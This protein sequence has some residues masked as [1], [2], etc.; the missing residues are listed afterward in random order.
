[1]V[2]PSG[3]LSGPKPASLFLCKA[4]PSHRGRE[5]DSASPF[6]ALRY[7]RPSVRNERTA[8][9]PDSP[10]LVQARRSEASRP[11]RTP[12]LCALSP[13]GADG[14]T[15]RAPVRTAGPQ[16]SAQAGPTAGLP[17]LP[18]APSPPATLRWSHLHSA[19]RMGTRTVQT[20]C[21]ADG[22][23]RRRATCPRHRGS[24]DGITVMNGSTRA[25]RGGLNA[26]RPGSSAQSVPR[27]MRRSPPEEGTTEPGEGPGPRD[28][29]A[30]QG[31]RALGART[32]ARRGT[33][34]GA[35]C[36]RGR[37]PRRGPERWLRAEQHLLAH[38]F[39]RLRRAGATGPADRLAAG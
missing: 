30:G 19:L 8:R 17:R 11:R 36:W 29:P 18:P 20:G 39:R 6:R 21:C 13:G 15:R 4:A 27:G 37:Q 16:G 35:V 38:R 22:G 34:P 28:T 31:P 2:R 5:P 9:P 10:G 7:S 14:R 26:S 25:G 1:M 3:R 12:G 33:G 23:R 32:E 24:A